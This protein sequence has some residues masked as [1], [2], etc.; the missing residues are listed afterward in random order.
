MKGIALGSKTKQTK[1]ASKQNKTFFIITAL[2]WPKTV[3]P[4]PHI[5]QLWPSR[6]IRIPLLPSSKKCTL[7]PSL[8]CPEGW[9]E[10]RI[11]RE[12]TLPTMVMSAEA[13]KNQVG[14]LDFHPKL[15]VMKQL[16]FPCWCSVRR[17]LLKQKIQSLIA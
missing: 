13:N 1:K 14:Q 7:P 5:Y 12:T 17:G 10:A 6:E 2:L 4:I 8:K 11:L 16:S 9:M 15:E 3:K